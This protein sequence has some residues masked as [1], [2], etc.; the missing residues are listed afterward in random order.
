MVCSSRIPDV[1]T[2]LMA[3]TPI[4]R[5]V[6][7]AKPLKL[8]PA[9]FVLSDSTGNLARHMMGAFL[10][11]FPPQAASVRFE[12]FLN[13]AERLA[14]VLEQAKSENA[15]VCHAMVSRE[16]KK[17]IQQFCLK[18]GLPCR[19]LT[20]GTVEFLAAITGEKPQRNLQTLHRMDDAYERRIGALEFTLSHDD[21]LGAETICDADIVLV[22]VS[23]TSK[24]PTSIY[25]A[26]QGYRVANVA[27]ALGLDPPAQLMKVRPE[28][29]FGLLINPQQLVMIRTRREA[30]WQMN[31]TS[32]GDPNHVS[33][34]LAW[35]RRLFKDSGWRTLDVTDQAIEETAARITA[36]V[37]PANATDRE[38]SYIPSRQPSDS[39][40]S[41][42][43][44]N[45]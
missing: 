32:Y 41:A 15:A 10:T 34:E 8:T 22:G 30:D 23:R 42:A 5:Q 29:V 6:R 39:R 2:N 35:T 36:I 20:G 7:A 18:A 1:S 13:T 44:E 37:G 3:Q 31:Q 21:S 19:D 38:K 9:I 24:T 26:Q 25:L 16:F 43:A 45:V 28:R 11:Q 14:T 12:S 33:R 4:K 40:D 17:V 27:L